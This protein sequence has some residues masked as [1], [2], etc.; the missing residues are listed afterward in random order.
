[1][2]IARRVNLGTWKGRLCTAAVHTP[3]VEDTPFLDEHDAPPAARKPAPQK[4]L[5][6]ERLLRTLN[7]RA[8]KEKEKK[9]KVKKLVSPSQPL[10]LRKL[11]RAIV[12]ITADF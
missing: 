3:L 12:A 4:Y 9:L 11:E 7:S 5:P 8:R 1:M 6:G 10:D 2:G